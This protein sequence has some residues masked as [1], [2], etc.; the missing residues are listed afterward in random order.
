MISPEGFVGIDQVVVEDPGAEL[1]VRRLEVASQ[2]IDLIPERLAADVQAPPAHGPSLALERLVVEVLV[3]GHED[4]EID[5]VTTARDQPHRPRRCLGVSTT[6]AAVDQPP[7]LEDLVLDTDDGDLLRLLGLIARHRVHDF[8][9]DGALSV[10]FFESVAHDF[11]RQIRLALGAVPA[12]GLLRLGVVASLAAWSPL[13]RITED[14][15]LHRSELLFEESEL[16]LRIDVAAT[17]ARDL[18]AETSV[19][20]TQSD[21]CFFKVRGD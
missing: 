7:V 20:L 8:A 15:S 19:L 9:T 14:C 5:G 12:A 21:G 13:R 18:G 2:R 3:L 11:D 10:I 4:R 1:V 17:K 6:L 16:H